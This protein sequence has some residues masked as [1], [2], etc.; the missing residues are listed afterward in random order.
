MKKQ[1]AKYLKTTQ[2]YTSEHPGKINKIIS[3]T[4]LVEHEE[5]QIS[6]RYR[7]RVSLRYLI[8]FLFC[9]VLFMESERYKETL[10]LKQKIK[11]K[12]G[13]IGTRLRLEKDQ[14]SEVSRNRYGKH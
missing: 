10:D 11:R 2:W 8:R 3:I 13:W 7:K 5:R 4:I 6:G 12:E 1:K 9:F 14:T